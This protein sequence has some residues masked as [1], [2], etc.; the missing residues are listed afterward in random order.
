MDLA[1]GLDNKHGE[2]GALEAGEWEREVN[3][4]TKVEV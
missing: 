2:N 4:V 1:R 3:V